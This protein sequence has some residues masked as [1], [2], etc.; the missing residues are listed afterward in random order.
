MPLRQDAQFHSIALPPTA[1]SEPPPYHSQGPREGSLDLADAEVLA[2]ILREWAATPHDCWFCVWD[3]YGWES[4]STF[5][6]VASAETGQPPET[7]APSR[8]DPVPGP[9]REGPRVQ[10]PNRSYLLYQGPAEAALTLPGLDGTFGQCPNLWWPADRAWCVASEIDLPWTYVGGPRGLIDAILADDRIE[11]LPAAPDDRV[12]RV[13]TGYRL[14]DQLLDGLLAHGTASLSTPRG[15]VDARLRRP[16]GTRPGD[17]RIEVTGP[18]GCSSSSWSPLGGGEEELRSNVH[19]HLTMAVLSLT[20]VATLLARGRSLTDIGR[21]VLIG[22]DES[23]PARLNGSPRSRPARWA[24]RVLGVDLP[25]G[26]VEGD[27]A[28]RAKA[29]DPPLRLLLDVD[30]TRLSQYP[31]VPRYPRPGNRQQRRQ[32]TRGRRTHSAGSAQAH[33]AQLVIGGIAA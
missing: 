4:A 6:S 8:R 3:G 21:Q 32:F 14:A 29:V 23:G 31:Q 12:N 5:F 13:R 22:R 33:Q 30:K 20:G 7:A 1:P 24:A 17:L 11:A 9:V 10:L 26:P 25:P 2:G 27:P 15:S 18:D 19:G 28:A 16:H